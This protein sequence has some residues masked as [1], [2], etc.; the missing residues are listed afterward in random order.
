[1]LATNGR[2]PVRHSCFALHRMLRIPPNPEKIQVPTR[3]I[4]AEIR[5]DSH[6]LPQHA[7]PMLGVAPR[8]RCG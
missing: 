5:P 7:F 1:M 3:R 2:V 4:V 6:H 8:I